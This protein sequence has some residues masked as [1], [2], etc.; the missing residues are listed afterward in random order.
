MDQLK[1]TEQFKKNL[2]SL[3]K[4]DPKLCAKLFDLILNILETPYSGI[5]HPE[6]LKGEESE[7]WSRRINEK[8]RLVYR[9][10]DGIVWLTSCYGHYKDK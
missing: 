9:V 6:P 10:I 7:Y 5:G 3:R 1:L 2:V 8:H 4:E